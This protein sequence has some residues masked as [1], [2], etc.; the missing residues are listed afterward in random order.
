M[1]RI[2]RVTLIDRVRGLCSTTGDTFASLE[3]K[4]DFGN[5]TIRKWNDGCPSGD[6]LA[7][8]AT[9]FHVSV[10]YL[11]G[12]QPTL[13]FDGIEETYLEFARIAQ[14]DGFDP[15]D[16]EI[17]MDTCAKLKRKYR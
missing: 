14:R 2:K 5:G 8:V 1:A 3:K 4:L 17:I 15:D 6:R 7:E 12:R 10:D 13:N 16:L 11:L 9:Y